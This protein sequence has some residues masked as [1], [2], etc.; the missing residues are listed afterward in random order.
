MIH[1]SIRLAELLQQLEG[2]SKYTESSRFVDNFE[3]YLKEMNISSDKKQLVGYRED[4]LPCL[5]CINE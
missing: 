3:S 1:E 4:V 5:F 2:D